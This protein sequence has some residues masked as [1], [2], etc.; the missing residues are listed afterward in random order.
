MKPILALLLLASLNVGAQTERFYIGTYTDKSPSQ[1]IYIGTLDAATGKLGP[2]ELASPAKNPSFL[3]LSP[4]GKFLY[5][6]AATNGGSVAA[7]RVEKNGRLIRLNDLP[8]GSGGCHVSVDSTGRN[9][10][11]ANYGGGSIASFSTQPNGA[12]DKRTALIAFTGSG[13]NLERQTKPYA[14]STCIDAGNRHLYAC[15]LGTDHVWCFDLDA[16]SGV[17][18][19]ANQPSASVPPGSGP[20]HLAFSPDQSIAYVNGEMGMNVTALTH[21]SKT[22]ALTAKETVST[23]P[24]DV[25]TDGMTTA[26]IFCHPTGK[27]LYV[28]NRDV[29][30]HDR[31]SLSVFAAGPNGQLTLIQNAPAGVKVPRGF[32]IDSTGCWLIVGGQADNQVTVFKI[33]TVTGKLSP[34][35][36]TAMVGSPV[37]VIFAK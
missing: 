10:F 35:G 31:D 24:P 23:L 7:Y 1:G 11:V 20:R 22:G 19:P 9:V 34:T 27:W 29:V 15:D 13:P 17:L 4:D 6:I 36:Q 21:D 37:C 8:S 33:D 16:A 5:A 28:S 30:G 25:D 3:A 26:E 18:T 14:H 12:L 2:L 32:N